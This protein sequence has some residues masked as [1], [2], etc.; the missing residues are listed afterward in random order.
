MCKDVGL[1]KLMTAIPGFPHL[2]VVLLRPPKVRIKEMTVTHITTI[3]IAGTNISLRTCSR[4]GCERIAWNLMH[5]L[6]RLGVT[7]SMCHGA[8]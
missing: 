7:E 3:N 5:G 6:M 8:W 1:M 2:E 4:A